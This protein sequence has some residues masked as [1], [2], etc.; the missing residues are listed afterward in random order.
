MKINRNTIID[1]NVGIINEITISFSFVNNAMVN[2]IIGNKY[3]RDNIIRSVL[4]IL[5]SRV[6]FIDSNLPSKIQNAPRPGFDEI[7]LNPF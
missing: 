3:I 4:W 1:I 7:T 2:P 5:I 6:P